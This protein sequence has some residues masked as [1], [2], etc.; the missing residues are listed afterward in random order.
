MSPTRI[1]LTAA[2]CAALG[3]PALARTEPA[4]PVV[5]VDTM[6]VVQT[7]AEPPVVIRQDSPTPPEEAWKLTP[8]DP[9]VVTNGPIPDT[10]ENRARYGGPMSGGGQRTAPSGN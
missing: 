7:S 4:S 9:A 3:G 2:V 10:Q 8:A 5:V 1:L 6:A